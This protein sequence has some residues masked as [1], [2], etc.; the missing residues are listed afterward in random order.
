[1]PRGWA[2]L[3]PTTALLRRDLLCVL[4]VSTDNRQWPVSTLVGTGHGRITVCCGASQNTSW[5]G[6]PEV[7]QDLAMD[8]PRKMPTMRPAAPAP[9]VAQVPA[10]EAAVVAAWPA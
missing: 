4:V 2:C 5:W 1:M 7:R 8:K 3:I 9:I 10:W 6:L